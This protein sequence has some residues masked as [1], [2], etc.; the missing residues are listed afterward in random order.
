MLQLEFLQ[1]CFNIKD[2][3]IKK[4]SYHLG[5]FYGTCGTLVG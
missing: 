3:Y 1:L 4:A 5:I 2:D